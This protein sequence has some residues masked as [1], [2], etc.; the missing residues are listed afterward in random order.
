MERKQFGKKG[1]F[2]T[3]IAISLIAAFILIFLPSN[4][5]LKKDIPVVKTR[6]TTINGYV[7]DLENVYLQKALQSSGT[8]TVIAL[9]NYMQSQNKF[10]ANFEDSFKEVLLNGTIDGQPIEPGIMAGNTY[11]DWLEKIRTTAD[12]AFTIST[13]F[14]ATTVNDISVYQ[15]RPWFLTVDAN[16]SF[17]VYSETASWNKNIVVRSEIDI[18]NFNDPYYLINTRGLYSNRINKSSV[19]FDEW[20]I[21]KTMDHIR[22][23][24]YVHFENSKAPSFIM[25]FTNTSLKSSCCGIE[26][27]VNPN[28]PAIGNKMESYVDYL[29]FN[30]T[31]QNMCTQLYNITEP[32]FKSEFPHFKLDFEHLVLYNLTESG[33]IRAC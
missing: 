31:Y 19:N 12:N 26:S 25:R 22:H 13:N 30:H 32:S 23:G 1:I 4:V 29:F 21:N 3:F 9:I 28:E 33:A 6:V 18:Q 24:T 27:V 7:T 17:I 2:L 15:T 10:L 5:S 14:N 20:D 8:K 11:P 16:V